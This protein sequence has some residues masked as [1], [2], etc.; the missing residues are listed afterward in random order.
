MSGL[1]RDDDA[2][3]AACNYVA[4]LFENNGGAIKV[5]PKDG[6][7]GCLRRGDAGGV[8]HAGDIAQRGGS[9][10]QGVNRVARGYV[11][12]RGSGLET[13]VAKDVRRRIGI[14]LLQVSEQHTLTRTDAT[15]NRLAD[16]SG[17]DDNDHIGHGQLHF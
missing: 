5:D 6:G 10:D 13:G 16:G 14:F 3:S 4:E 12:D 9:M 2:R 8:D 1:R 15:G 17:P 7:W 11:Y